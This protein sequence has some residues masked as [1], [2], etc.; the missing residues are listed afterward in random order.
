MSD[1]SRDR[2]NPRKRSER[3]TSSRYRLS[4]PPEVE[5]LHSTSRTP[6]EARLGDLSRGGCYVETDFVLPVDTEVAI[7][8]KK[9]GEQVT[10]QARIVRVFP[11]A[12]LALAFTSMEGDGF[13]ILDGW[14]SAFVAATWVAANRRRTQ[15]VAMQVGVRVSG[16]DTEGA[17]FTVDTKT[18]EI[19]VSGGSVVLQTVVRPGQ[20][21]VLSNQETKATV[22]CMVVQCGEKGSARQ[23]GFAFIVANQSFWPIVFPPADWSSRALEATRSSS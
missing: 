22:E 11:N 20:R 19:S 21:L 17:R 1:N 15:R 12:G 5:I 10:A 8:L 13:Q 23:V 14:L 6:I 3:R 7:V 2:N 16:Y 4:Q 9:R 18:V